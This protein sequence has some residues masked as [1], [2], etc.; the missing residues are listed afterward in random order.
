MSNCVGCTMG[1]DRHIEKLN[2]EGQSRYKKIGFRLSVNEE[3]N[4]MKVMTDINVFGV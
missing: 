2:T 3:S 1:I 4:W